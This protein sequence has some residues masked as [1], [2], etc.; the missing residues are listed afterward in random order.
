MK[1]FYF[2]ALVIYLLTAFIVSAR[3]EPSVIRPYVGADYTFHDFDLKG[4][5]EVFDDTLH[6]GN[7]H[8][9][10]R[11]NEYLGAE[12]GYFATKTAKNSDVAG[13]EFD[14]KVK[15]EGLTLDAFGYYPAGPVE[16]VATG[17]VS[18]ADGTAAV[19]GFEFSE[20][21]FGYRAG[22]GLQYNVSENV[23]VRG[24]VRWQ[25][26]DFKGFAEDAITYS[27]GINYSF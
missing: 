2:Y 26:A 19:N 4:G 24:L 6:G 23:S 13:T 7:V 9:G 18:W 10:A 17:G 3:A 21:E 5:D 25:S 8:F 12:I 22:G 15:W 16:L 1:R 14:T 11:F 27:A 20:D